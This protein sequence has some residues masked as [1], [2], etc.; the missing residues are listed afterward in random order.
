M[1]GIT[2]SN[3]QLLITNIIDSYGHNR[4]IE[5]TST[6]RSITG[7]SNTYNKWSL[8]GTNLHFDF[9]FKV[10]SGTTINSY[11]ILYDYALPSWV[12]DRITTP[13]HIANKDWVA[14]KEEKATNNA[15]VPEGSAYSFLLQ[16]DTVGYVHLYYISGTRTAS[17]DEYFRVT[18]DLLID[19]D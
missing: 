13:S 4:F 15:G 3:N 17:S 5:G 7:I 16:K 1:K 14:V 6:I 10:N 9:C 11:V 12:Y 19:L 2:N 8:S 18:F